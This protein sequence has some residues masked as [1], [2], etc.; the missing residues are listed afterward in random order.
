MDFM[1]PE[2]TPNNIPEN[3]ASD[4]SDRDRDRRV[5]L[6]DAHLLNSFV[7]RCSH[8]TAE[9]KEESLRELICFENNENANYVISGFDANRVKSSLEA[10]VGDRQETLR[11]TSGGASSN[12]S[13]SKTPPL[14]SIETESSLMAPV[15]K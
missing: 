6:D 8:L 12:L 13:A 14:L 7:E 10:A 2:N 11:H 9:A 5:D 3:S 1:Y 15:A 4:N